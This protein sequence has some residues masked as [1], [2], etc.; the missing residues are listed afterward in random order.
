MLRRQYQRPVGVAQQELIEARQRE[1]G[2][3]TGDCAVVEQGRGLRRE[4]VA[5][6][7]ELQLHQLALDLGQCRP[8]LGEGDPG[9]PGKVPFRGGAVAAQVPQQPLGDALRAL[10][11]PG[12]LDPVSKGDHQLLV[13]GQRALH[14][15]SALAQDAQQVD[16]ALAGSGLAGPLEGL[17]QLRPAGGS[18][19]GDQLQ[20]GNGRS[21]DVRRSNSE[22][23]VPP[24]HAADQAVGGN[25]QHPLQVLGSQQVQG[26]PH[27]PGTDDLAPVQRVPDVARAGA[28]DPLPD[29]PEG[30]LQVLG[31][32]RRH[33]PDCPG[34]RSPCPGTVVPGRP[35][36][37]GPWS[38]G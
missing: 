32:H 35:A 27:R 15:Q 11:A 38:R 34:H 29:R 36:G 12:H 8:D 31:L 10:Q 25:V 26:A 16:P 4:P 24:R 22:L 17:E 28:G 14:Q 5:G 9:P 37:A 33:P 13:A 7:L 20:P 23:P 19:A 6:A 3:C 2:A 1:H 18:A 30:G 21:V